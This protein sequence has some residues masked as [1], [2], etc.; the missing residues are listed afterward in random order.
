MDS[1][2]KWEW[3]GRVCKMGQGR[4]YI[5]VPKPIGGLLYMKNIRVVVEV[6]EVEV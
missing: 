2:K 4:Y 3:V 6:V 1:E 5:N